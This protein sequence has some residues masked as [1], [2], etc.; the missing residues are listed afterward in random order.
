MI[1]IQSEDDVSIFVEL[2]S[3][4][5][6]PGDLS[7]GI[8]WTRPD[9][10][11]SGFN[12]LRD[13]AF[14]TSS[15]LTMAGLYGADRKDF[16]H[17]LLL[18]N[19]TTEDLLV[20]GTLSIRTVGGN[21]RSESLSEELDPYEGRSIDLRD[22]VERIGDKVAYATLDLHWKGPADGLIAVS[23]SLQLGKGVQIVNP[24]VDP[25]QSRKQTSNYVVRVSEGFNTEI[26]IKNPTDEPRRIVAHLFLADGEE[27]DF[28]IL[29]VAAHGLHRID[30][31]ELQREQTPDRS[32][33]YLPE[34]E[35]EGQL[36]WF[37]FRSPHNLI[38]RAILSLEDSGIA[39][40]FSCV[41]CGIFVPDQLSLTFTSPEIPRP[42]GEYIPTTGELE[43][44]D[45]GNWSQ[46]FTTDVSGQADYYTSS[47]PSVATVDNFG[48]IATQATGTA[49]IQGFMEVEREICELATCTTIGFTVQQLV[50][51]QTVVVDC[52]V[53]PIAAVSPDPYPLDIDNMTA[54]TQTALSCLQTG[55]S[56]AGGS[57]TVIS[58]FR[59]DWYQTHLRE[60]WDKWQIVRQ[61][62]QGR[63]PTVRANI[64][65]EWVS[66]GIGSEPGVTSNHSAGTAFDA[67]WNLPTGHA[68]ID[69]L[70]RGY[71]LARDVPGDDSHF[72]LQ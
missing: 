37:P 48:I 18:Q 25:Q 71:N 50:S 38:G 56:N 17:P 68:D 26:E 47:D 35:F 70:A 43:Y 69:T 55:V 32:Q 40:S 27:Y 72:H 52:G 14:R 19:T 29:T 23:H 58:A 51:S 54:A 57:L 62:P 24:L 45:C 59:P 46:G 15:S 60:V 61:W 4:E 13:P 33:R 53:E 42:P 3:E 7:G 1:E 36:V 44:V 30:L 31:A 67:T 39:G 49:T 65:A 22:W 9:L 34:G 10:G 64:Q 2:R 16:R 41:Q 28:G 66:H 21:T 11:L 20:R 12:P 8:F 5:A 6:T 63:C